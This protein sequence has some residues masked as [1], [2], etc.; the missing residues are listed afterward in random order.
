MNAER[1]RS[2]PSLFIVHHSSFIVPS[3]LRA[4]FDNEL[5]GALVSPRLVT[6]GGLTP[7]TH[8][9]TSAGS[10]A[11]TAAQGMID[12]IHRDAAVVRH[13]SHVTLAAGLADGHVFVL[14]ISDLTDGG[15][16]T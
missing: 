11:F 7:R 1:H 16:A 2:R 10:L 14:E 12:G 13:L 3:L 4:T 15:V 8:R 9:M 5:R 6:L